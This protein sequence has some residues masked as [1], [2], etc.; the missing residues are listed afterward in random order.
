[1]QI[2]FKKLLQKHLLLKALPIANMHS[3][4]NK[5]NNCKMEQK[6]E[7]S[8]IIVP[9]VEGHKGKTTGVFGIVHI[10]NGCY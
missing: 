4:K 6:K 2:V 9:S 7:A 5:E 8:N 3:K 1:M 10:N